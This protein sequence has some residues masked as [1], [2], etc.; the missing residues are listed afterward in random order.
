MKNV[1]FIESLPAALVFAAVVVI[2]TSI[3][4]AVRKNK[5]KKQN[6]SL[7]PDNPEIKIMKEKHGYTG[8]Q[9]DVT[10][11]LEMMKFHK[12][13]SPLQAWIKYMADK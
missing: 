1:G 2:Y 7:Q 6:E 13:K 12:I 11:V 3:K 5:S 9:K 4:S 10:L 8:S